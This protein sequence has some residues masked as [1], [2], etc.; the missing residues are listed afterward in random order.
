MI[1]TQFLKN[2]SLKNSNSL[3]I[4]DNLIEKYKFTILKDTSEFDVRTIKLYNNNE[5]IIIKSKI[6]FDSNLQRFESI[7][8]TY[9]LMNK[10]ISNYIF[11]G[12][13]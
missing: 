8:L 13:Y 5:Y 11:N 6:E 4:I 7:D 1:L 12:L 9:K 10:I 3:F 2:N